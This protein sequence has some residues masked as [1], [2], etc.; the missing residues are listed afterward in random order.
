MKLF[1]PIVILIIALL[2]LFPLVLLSKDTA[3][4]HGGNSVYRRTYP[5]DVKSIDP[6]T[7]GDDISSIIQANFYEGLYAYHYLKR[8]VEVV[9]QLAAAMPEISA[10]GLTY[11]IRLKPGVLYH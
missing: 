4:N 6:A 3:E 2:T 9:P 8:P 11:T 1:Y 7:C 5:A 10:D